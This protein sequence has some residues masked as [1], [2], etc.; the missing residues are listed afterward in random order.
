VSDEK[1]GATVDLALRS[2]EHHSA[3]YEVQQSV[4]NRTGG[5]RD[6][7]SPMPGGA[8]SLLKG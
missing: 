7:G 3:S 4:A 2:A 6:R 8:L 1:P 5:A